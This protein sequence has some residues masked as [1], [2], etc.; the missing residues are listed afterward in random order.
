MGRMVCHELF[1]FLNSEQTS[2]SRHVMLQNNSYLYFIQIPL[3]LR[4][5][6]QNDMN[7]EVVAKIKNTCLFYSRYELQIK[8]I[9]FIILTIL[10]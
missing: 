6:Y 3:F 5:R 2:T 8:F 10:Y 9:Q 1:I 4:N 7:Q